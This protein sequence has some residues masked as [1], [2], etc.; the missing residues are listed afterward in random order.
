M[1]TRH[2]PASRGLLMGMGVLLVLGLL[3]CAPPTA[4]AQGVHRYDTLHVEVPVRAELLISNRVLQELDSLSAEAARTFK[5]KGRCGLGVYR[6]ARAWSDLLYAPEEIEV[7]D[8]SATLGPC[9]IATVLEWHTHLPTEALGRTG[10]VPRFVRNPSENC[11]LS[12]DDL[13]NVLRSGR[14]AAYHM[15]HV[16]PGVYCWW[17]YAQVVEYVRQY[18]FT[19]IMPALQ[20]QKSW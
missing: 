6:E 11:F 12:Q 2:M 1:S 19:R 13:R 15:V 14:V 10:G 9:P 8:T 5:E 20:Y 3:T 16:Q 17:N 18:Q 4:P 7:T